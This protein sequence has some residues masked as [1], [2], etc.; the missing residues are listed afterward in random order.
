MASLA[1]ANKRI[2]NFSEMIAIYR[3]LVEIQNKLIAEQETAI[4]KIAGKS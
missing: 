4:L 3:S 2:E 1:N